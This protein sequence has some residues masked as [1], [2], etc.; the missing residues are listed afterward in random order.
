MIPYI[1]LFAMFA[2]GSLDDSARR[3]VLRRIAAFC[4]MLMIGLRFEVGADWNGYVRIFEDIRRVGLLSAVTRGD[5]GFYGLNWLVHQAGLGF[6]A[7]NLVCAIIFTLGLV[8]FVERQPNPWLAI[9]ISIPVLSLIVAMSGTRQAT[10]IGFVLFALGAFAEGRM[11]RFL[12]FVGVGTMFH[13]SAIL[14]LPVAALS[15]TK[16]RLQAGLVIA[17]G[18]ALVEFLLT[19]QFDV[20]VARYTGGD[21]GSQGAIF[22]LAMNFIPGVLFLL[23]SRRYRVEEH[24]RLLWRNI[25]FL[26]VAS[27]F[28]LPLV[29]SSTALDRVA[30]YVIPLQI[31]VLSRVPYVFGGTAQAQFLIK[32]AVIAFSATVLMVF[33]LASNHGEYWL[34]YQFY[35]LAEPSL[36]DAPN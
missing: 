22:R 16:N 13:A 27:L 35:P 28:L 3:R 7:V 11:L 12:V 8:R 9:V 17:V 23:A 6:W 34:P 24:E 21:P 14:M 15:Y 20:Y 10:A 33:L 5:P 32:L 30:F 26:A 19:S 36:E 2:L 1:V 31:F 29:P 25:S 18:F 4:L